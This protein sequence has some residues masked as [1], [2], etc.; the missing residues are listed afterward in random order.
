MKKLI[1]EEPFQTESG[2][3]IAHLEIAYHTYGTLN[4]AGDNVIWVC[5][6]LTANSDVEAWWPGMVGNGLL[7]DTTDYFIVCANILGSC[8]GT[9]GPADINPRT[10]KPWLNSF[11]DIT[12]R[13]LVNAHEILR[14]HLG[15]NGIH[16]VIGASIGGFQALEYSIMHPEL[17]RH[18][19]F[20]ASSVRQTPWAIAFN[21]SQRLAMEADESFIVN[22]PEGGRKGLK[23][24]RAVALLS[25]RS[26]FAYNLTQKDDDDKTD[27]FK[28]SSYQSYQG[29]KLVNRF[30]PY[31][32]YRLTKLSDTHNVG[33][34]RGGIV[35]A[36]GRIKAYVLAIGISS[37]YLFPVGEQKLLA[38]SVEGAFYDE[39][40]SMYGHDGF[41]IEADLITGVIRDFWKNS[42]K[43]KYDKKRA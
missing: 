6:A 14:L 32:Y 17:I 25:Y 36:L 9:T 38:D 21:E 28:A 5:H 39:I 10:G 4:R 30:N 27:S 22:N 42:S 18:L 8:Y 31:S 2:T 13:D 23:A 40:D 37:D 7:L 12:V 24:A 19:V 35:K 1:S 15:I 11:P 20:I 29:D 43:E 34:G 3:V 26:A 16:T 33:R 41:L